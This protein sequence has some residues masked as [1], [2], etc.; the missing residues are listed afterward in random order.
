MNKV[1]HIP[2]GYKDSPLGIIPKEWEVKKLG[3]VC[4]IDKQSLSSSTDPEYEFYYISLSDVNSERFEIKSSRQVFKSAPSRA[5][6]I[7]K[8]GDVVIS[9]VRPNLQAFTFIRENV[10][11]VIV[12]T[13]FAVLTPKKILGEYLFQY[14]LFFF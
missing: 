11:D 9:T 7:I 6:R 5:R 4:D 3:E 8:K 10:K 13:G 2:Q 14:L 12:S 1:K